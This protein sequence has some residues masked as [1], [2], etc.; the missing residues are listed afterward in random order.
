MWCFRIHIYFV[1]IEKR[2]LLRIW[3]PQLKAHLTTIVKNKNLSVLKR[4]HGPGIGVQVRIWRNASQISTRTHDLGRWNLIPRQN[5][6]QKFVAKTLNPAQ[7]KDSTHK[8]AKTLNPPAPTP[9]ENDSAY[10]FWWRW[11]ASRRPW[12]LHRCCWPWLPSRARSPH[13]QSQ[14]RTSS[15]LL[16]CH[17]AEATTSAIERQIHP[18][19]F[20]IRTRKYSYPRLEQDL[21]LLLT[22]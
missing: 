11:R 19:L 16:P 20:R 2:G 6:S 7:G 17:Q 8:A 10:Q 21:Q 22:Q 14:W 13:L 15:S 3:C 1:S 18:V 5:D 12:E 9:E 4:W